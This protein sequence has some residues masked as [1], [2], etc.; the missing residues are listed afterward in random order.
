MFGKKKSKEDSQDDISFALPAMPDVPDEVLDV[1]PAGGRQGAPIEAPMLNKASVISPGVLIK[2]S[3]QSPGPLHFQ[4]EVEGEVTAPQVSLGPTA[5]MRGKLNCEELAIHGLMEGEVVCG[6][7]SMGQTARLEGSV[8]C[9]TLRLAVGAVVNGE[10]L[11][12]KA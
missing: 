6:E 2:G 3:I 8:R 11:V 4:G 9:R 7:L 5:K 1:K 10:V 12:G